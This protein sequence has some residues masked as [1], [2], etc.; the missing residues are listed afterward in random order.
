MKHAK[1]HGKALLEEGKKR[2]ISYGKAQLE[3]GTQ[4]AKGQA[5][6][7]GERVRKKVENIFPMLPARWKQ[8]LVVSIAECPST[9]VLLLECLDAR[10]LQKKAAGG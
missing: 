9:L 10:L 1:V 2:A 5:S 7:A 4:W 3:R 6:A 8:L